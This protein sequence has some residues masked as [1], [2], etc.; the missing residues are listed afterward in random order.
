MHYRTLA[1]AGPGPPPA[2]GRRL[3][4][5]RGCSPG[6][7]TRQAPCLL[8]LLR[9]C[10]DWAVFRTRQCCPASGRS[11]LSFPA[12]SL[13]S[14]S[15][16]PCLEY[17]QDQFPTCFSN[18]IDVI[19]SGTAATASNN[20]SRP[21]SCAACLSKAREERLAA[22]PGSFWCSIHSWHFRAL[23]SRSAPFLTR[24]T[25]RTNTFTRVQPP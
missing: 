6:L 11:L 9:G 20:D 12:P 21:L 5:G 17:K 4:A 2:P 8:D 24:T 14:T 7:P 22:F 18:R 3:P 1:P 13:L 23:A 19:S 25:T 15:S 16:I 10:R